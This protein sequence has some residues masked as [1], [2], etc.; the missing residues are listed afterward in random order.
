MS[1]RD[2]RDADF[3]GAVLS[4]A[5]LSHSKFD[6]AIFFGAD[7]RGADLRYATFV[8]SD[9]R[10]ACLRGVRADHASFFEAD[11]R[12]GAIAERGP[13]GRL[14]YLYH[15]IGN[16]LAPPLVLSGT[17]LEHF[18]GDGD[19]AMHA[20]FTDASL[21]G[22]SF[23]E[24]NLKTAKFHGADLSEANFKAA[25]LTEVDFSG[26]VL[27][28]VNF[29]LAKMEDTVR[30]L[31]QK[32]DLRMTTADIAEVEGKLKGHKDWV[33]SGGVRGAPGQFANVDMRS[34][35]SLTGGQFTALH[36]PGSI[37]SG[38][39]L[40]AI[41]LQGANLHNADFR[42]AT[43]RGADLRGIDFRGADLS[44]CKFDRANLSPL[45]LGKAEFTKPVLI[46]LHCVMRE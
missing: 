38:L 3:S 33:E 30:D 25:D 37:W 18:K 22:T 43:L 44:G 11:M 8:R 17:A 26:A 14:N 34:V 13:M 23:E 20:D 32:S 24:A 1:N 19:P 15:D 41:N 10:G 4:K 12:D 21:R 6:N 39:D 28:D 31:S 35:R 16:P 36:A 42:G 7:L 40:T 45:S 5:D 27:N 29:I 2:F 46:M 9:F